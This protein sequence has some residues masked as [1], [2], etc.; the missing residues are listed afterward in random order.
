MTTSFDPSP[1][2][3]QQELR[4]PP[5][6]PPAL[7]G[8]N[9]LHYRRDPL[10]FLVNNAK[11]YGDINLIMFAKWYGFQL[12]HPDDVQ[13]VL[14][15]QVHKFRKGVIYKATLSEYLGNGLL[16]SDGDFW[17]RQ[18]HLAQP[19]FHSKRIQ[20]YATV[21]AEF[22]QHMLN[23]WK[24]GETR[25]I[26]HDMMSLTLFIVAKTLFDTI[27]AMSRTKWLRH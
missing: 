23:S 9:L 8:G 24:V 19:A 1:P 13:Q 26:A 6:K 2:T 22:T 12:N 11:Q 18:R 17:R 3:L 7:I 25:D 27:L 5:G 15:K 20:A 4:L 14:V 10:G 21:M 16:I